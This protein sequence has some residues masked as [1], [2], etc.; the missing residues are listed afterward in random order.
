MY[1]SS[2]ATR[3]RRTR[4]NASDKDLEIVEPT[5]IDALLRQIPKCSAVVT[6][7]QLATDVFCSHYGVEGP[8]VGGYVPFSLDSRELRLYR[9][10]SSSRAYPMKCERKAELYDVVFKYLKL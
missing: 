1:S 3:I 2:P 6:A 7:G 8:K 4:D 9:M 5:D 10:P